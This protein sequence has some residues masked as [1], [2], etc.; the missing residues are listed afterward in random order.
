MQKRPAAL[1]RSCHDDDDDGEN[2]RDVANDESNEGQTTALVA[3]LSGFSSGLMPQDDSSG[4]KHEGAQQRQD[5]GE[6]TALGHPSPSSRRLIGGRVEWRWNRLTWFRRRCGEIGGVR[7]CSFRSRIARESRDRLAKDL[8]LQ[9]LV[10]RL[11]QH[12]SIP[13][14]SEPAQF[15]GIVQVSHPASPSSTPGIP[16]PP[17]VR[18]RCHRHRFGTASFRHANRPCGRKS[19]V[20]PHGRQLAFQPSPQSV[21]ASSASPSG[22]AAMARLISPMTQL[23]PRVASTGS[24]CQ[25]TTMRS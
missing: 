21:P 1:Y 24:I 22:L 8:V 10:L 15:G 18:F 9:S 2:R 19:K 3:R 11:R 23:M 17:I 12:T 16:R 4:P 20:R 5:G 13:Q 6:I 25:S 14:L 7:L